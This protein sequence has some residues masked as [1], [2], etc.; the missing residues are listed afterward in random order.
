MKL[1]TASDVIVD[2]VAAHNQRKVE[3]ARNEGVRLIECINQEKAKIAGCNERIKALRE[4]GDKF[5]KDVISVESVFGGSLPENANSET[6]LKVVEA[7]NKARQFEVEQK[8][9]RYT[10]SITQEQDAIKAIQLRT[11]KYA[12]QLKALKP[13]VV[14]VDQIVG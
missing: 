12:E 8:T 7:A 6:I 11:D 14:T 3:E 5:S 2:A 1:N 4:E 9:K 13:A 10:D